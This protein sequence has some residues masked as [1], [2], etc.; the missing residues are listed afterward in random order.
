MGFYEM[1]VLH[2]K[3]RMPILCRFTGSFHIKGGNMNG[4]H[5]L[6]YKGLTDGSLS[7]SPFLPEPRLP[8]C[9]PTL[10]RKL[11]WR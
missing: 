4:L 8:R 7:I 3:K 1:L 9:N 10:F 2:Q 11:L 6:V 5:I